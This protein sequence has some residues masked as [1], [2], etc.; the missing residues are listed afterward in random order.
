MGFLI[1]PGR[2]AALKI[3]VAENLADATGQM[4]P[5]E[6]EDATLVW[7]RVPVRLGYRFDLAV[8]LDDLVPLLEV[9]QEPGF[10]G[11]RVH[12]GSD[13]FNAEW[14][15]HDAGG[16]LRIESNWNS[17]SG[18]YAFLLNER[19]RVTVGV[20]WFVTEWLKVLRRITSDVGVHG[21][22]LKDEELAVRAGNLLAA[23]SI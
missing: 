23:R 5:M 16:A 7:N 8:M 1:Q 12:W 3:D 17:V 22:C 14:T 9:V 11:A 21:V 2:P 4:Y 18:G 19:S 10:T 6:N 15:I 13:T 20:G